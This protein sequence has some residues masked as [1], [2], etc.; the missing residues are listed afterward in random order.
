MDDTIYPPKRPSAQ[1][2]FAQ[3]LNERA[4]TNRPDAG[5][6]PRISHDMLAGQGHP[7]CSANTVQALPREQLQQLI[8]ALRTTSQRPETLPQHQVQSPEASLQVQLENLSNSV[9]EVRSVVQGMNVRL[10]K[11]ENRV[12][13][14]GMVKGTTALVDVVQELRRLKGAVAAIGR[15]AILKAGPT[16]QKAEMQAKEG[17]SKPPEKKRKTASNDAPEPE[18]QQMVTRRQLR[19]GGSKVNEKEKTTSVPPTN[20]ILDAVER[21]SED[22]AREALKTAKTPRRSGK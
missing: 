4:N 2:R 8:Q 7:S 12:E 3:R 6:T 11:L 18:L 10:A 17:A 21:G 5:A 22:D 9:L 1:Q 14:M 13:G 19:K 20:A 15:S 16:D